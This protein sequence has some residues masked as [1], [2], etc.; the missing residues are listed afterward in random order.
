[1]VNL[2]DELER[3]NRFPSKHT[4]TLSSKEFTKIL[5]IKESLKDTYLPFQKKTEKRFHNCRL[6]VQEITEE[7]QTGYGQL[8]QLNELGQLTPKVYKTLISKPFQSSEQ[9]V[10]LATQNS[11]PHTRL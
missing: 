9:L 7:C 2:L 1:M 4:H 6:Q 8:I 11:W 5:S 3:F 10:K